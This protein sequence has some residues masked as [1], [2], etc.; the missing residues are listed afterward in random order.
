MRAEE[1]LTEVLKAGG[2]DL[3]LSLP[4]DRVKL[5]HKMVIE[6]FS[7]IELTREEEGVGI[8]AGAA[9]TGRRPALLIQSSGMG[10][11]VNALAS[12]TQFYG[13]PLLLMFSWRGVYKEGI[14]AQ[15]PMGALLPRL[16]EA[17]GIEYRILEDEG[18]L[19]GLKAFISECYGKD[20]VRALLMSSRLWEHTKLKSEL[21]PSEIRLIPSMK[22]ATQGAAAKYTRHEVLKGIKEE[23]KGKVVV[24]NIGVPS[25]ELYSLLDQPSNFY[26]MGSMGMATP[27]GLGIA[28]CADKEVV[29]LDGDGSLLM[30]PGTLAV[31][32]GN[33]SPHLSIIALDN[34]A[35]GSTGDQPSLTG[36]GVNLQVLAR[37]M[38][39]YNTLAADSPDEVKE[40]LSKGK[41]PRFIHAI[42]RPGN[43]KVPNIPLTAQEIKKRVMGAL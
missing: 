32:A 13:L 21:W 26:M 39:F 42:I 23:L 31:A 30:N 7:H 29:V 11:M 12:L 18:D 16:L 3:V 33:A 1:L 17:M 8:A 25:K 27:I 40:A 5:L 41:G 22:V 10:N 14:E 6:S 2:V 24:S 43:A 4:C 28:M 15:K 37:A 34:A 19:A 36:K 35:Y 20:K 9:L 38:G